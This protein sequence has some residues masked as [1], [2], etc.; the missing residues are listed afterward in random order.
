MKTKTILLASIVSIVLLFNGCGDKEKKKENSKQE[1]VTTKIKVT[2]NVVKKDDT[3]EVSK[4]NSGQFYYS[5]NK[6]GQSSES[7]EIKTYNQETSKTKTTIDAYLNVKS[8]YEKVRITM[9]IKR[10]SKDYIIKCSPC[11]DDYANGV[12]GPSLLGKDKHFI[13]QRIIDFKT[14]KK[15]NVLM[16]ELVEQIDNKKLEHI[17]GEIADFNKQI[18][19]MRIAK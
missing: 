6:E 15:K 8:P 18:Q 11:H 2:K 10:L 1:T 4:E 17:A 14:G 7:K 13:Y 12:I 19:K 9:M 3:K 5:Y 16:K